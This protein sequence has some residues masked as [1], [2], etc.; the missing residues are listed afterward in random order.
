MDSM[1]IIKLPV[2]NNFSNLDVYPADL[3]GDSLI[4]LFNV[5]PIIPDLTETTV[6]IEFL[7]D[8][9]YCL[10]PSISSNNGYIALHSS[11]PAF[12][13]ELPFYFCIKK[14]RAEVMAKSTKQKCEDKYSTKCANCFKYH[15]PSPN[16]MNCK[17]NKTKHIRLRGGAD[18]NLGFDHG[19]LTTV[20]KRGIA[21]AKSHGINMQGGVVNNGDGNKI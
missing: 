11:R 1:K 12:F 8:H 21:N 19:S 16:T 5:E 18:S 3:G 10:L 17:W 9:I 20:T 15:F 7:P 6:D 14:M 2:I 13:N 4:Y